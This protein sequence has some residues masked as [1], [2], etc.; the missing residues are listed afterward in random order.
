MKSKDLSFE[1]IEDFAD[2]I[3]EKVECDEELFMSIVGKYDEIKNI[4]KEI[5]TISDVD[6]EKICLYSDEVDDYKDEYI[7]DCYC[8]DG[9]VQIGCEPAKRDGKYLNLVGDEIYLLDNVSSKIIPLCAESDLYFVYIEDECDCDDGCYCDCHKDDKLIECSTG[10]DGETHGFTASKSDDNGYYSFSF[11]TTNSL[12][13][14]D[15]HSMLKEF[16]F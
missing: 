5:I 7:L 8:D 14:K 12:S 16:G 2:Y 3:V 13:E 9:V 6:F 1:Y 10:V 15:I 4:I 11:Y